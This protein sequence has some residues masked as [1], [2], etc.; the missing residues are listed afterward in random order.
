VEP[1][2]GRGA[3]LGPMVSRLI[4]SARLHGHELSECDGAIRAFDIRAE[5]VAAARALVA[6]SFADAGMPEAR[7]ERLA[8]TSVR[9]CDFLLDPLD[10]LVAD[11]V[12]G[13]PP[14]VRIEGVAA[15][16]TAAYRRVCPTMRGR[17]DVYVGFFERG[18]RLLSDGGALGFIAPDRWM[19]NQYGAGLRQLVSE[20]FS[21]DA[22]VEMHDVDAFER[23]VSTYPAVTVIRRTAQEKAVVA[24]ANRT[25]GP[26]GAGELVRWVSSGQEGTVEG[27]SFSAVRLSEW[28]GGPDLW[29][30]G[31]PRAIALVRLLED[32]FP[33]LED[34]A[35]GTR[36]GIGVATGADG[37]YVTR[38]AGLV[39]PDRLLPLVAAE[40]VRCG[41]V[42]WSGTYLVN[43]WGERGLVDLRS[44]PRLRDYY[45]RHR[46]TL[47]RRHVAKANPH[48]WYRTIDSVRSDLVGVPKLLV[49]HMQASLF[50]ALDAGG[51]YPHGGLYFITSRDWDLEVL[52]G[53][54]LSEFANLF[55]GTYCTKLR[56]G[57]YQVQA[58]YLR[59]VRVPV[60]GS[61]GASERKALRDAFR[62]RDREKATAVAMGLF[63]V[64]ALPPV[65]TGPRCA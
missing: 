38:D 32:R 47:E 46:R 41:Q 43:P 31:D 44:Y 28:H 15:A 16:R 39:E 19:H 13:N 25:F 1:A 20:R 45:E 26:E 57:Y 24:T 48:G 56:G 9:R 62:E 52:G 65:A 6:R 29:P 49:P 34:P 55:V 4:A 50:P 36:V 51:L 59:K 58:Q 23:A 22:V 18:L 8:A 12:L 17:S 3:F 7:A 35:T 27:S 2:C 64:E 10:G 63:G 33:P 42:Q 53:L 14:Y 61:V 5:N 40:D 54:L 30:S 11:F 21:V 37:V 60:I